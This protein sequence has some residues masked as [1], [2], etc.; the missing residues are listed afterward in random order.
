MCLVW[1]FTCLMQAI[2]ECCLWHFVTLI[3]LL[4]YAFQ[5]HKNSAQSM[6][7]CVATIYDLHWL[8]GKQKFISARFKG[9]FCELW[10]VDFDQ[11]CIFLFARFIDGDGRVQSSCM[12]IIG[13]SY[14]YDQI[15]CITKQVLLSLR[16]S[17][18]PA[19]RSVNMLLINSHRSFFIWFA[20]VWC[21]WVLRLYKCITHQKCQISGIKLIL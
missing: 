19:S 12:E 20:D 6:V 16:S 3:F 11:F 17:N 9:H 21:S 5:Y 1:Y 18:L 10:W 13:R 7:L 2:Q 14:A 15:H 8:L 4:Y